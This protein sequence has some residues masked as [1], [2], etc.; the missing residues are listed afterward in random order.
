MP[1]T[2]GYRACTRHM[3]KKDY[4]TNGVI[5]LGRYLQVYKV[6]FD[7]QSYLLWNV[8]SWVMGRGH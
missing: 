4:K 1:H 5:P 7:S 8:C 2:K 3:F 6:S